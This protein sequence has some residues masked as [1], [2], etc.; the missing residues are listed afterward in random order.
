MGEARET[1]AAVSPTAEQAEAIDKIARFVVRFGMTVPAILAIE[2]MRPLSFVG[3]Q[4]MHI[5]SPSV[6]AVLTTSQWDALARLLERREGLEFILHR[7]EELDE[8][9]HLRRAET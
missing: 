2:G 3:S 4:F 9:E 8:A 7:I 5:L 1:A 6:G